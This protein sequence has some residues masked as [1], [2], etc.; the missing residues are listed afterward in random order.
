MG[1]EEIA[2]KLSEYAGQWVAVAD[3][4]VVESANTLDELLECVEGQ[5]QRVEV[6]RVPQNPDAV[7]FF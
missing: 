3:R 5:E 7:S 2:A 6:F 1:A 4:A